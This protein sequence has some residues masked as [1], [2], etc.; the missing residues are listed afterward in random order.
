MAGLGAS[1]CEH[2]TRGLLAQP[3]NAITSLGFALAGGWVISRALRSGRRVEPLVFGASIIATGVGSFLYHGPQP[4]HADAA[5][6]ASI[7]IL[8]SQV[9]VYEGRG[10]LM[11]RPPEP[12]SFRLAVASL[13]IAAVLFAFGRTSSPLCDPDSPVQLHGAWHVVVALSLAAYGRARLE[14]PAGDGTAL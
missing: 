13:G 11:K 14:N 9:I 3:T 4:P 6:D 2:V 1:D 10:R 7:L 8:L 12:R 5:H